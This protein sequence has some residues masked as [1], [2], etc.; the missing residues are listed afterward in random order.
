MVSER[1]Y[2]GQGDGMDK[3][4]E[5]MIRVS[6]QITDYLWELINEN[7]TLKQELKQIKNNG[8]KS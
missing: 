6:H 8:T 2:R 1:I 5:N 3:R 7:E 4:E